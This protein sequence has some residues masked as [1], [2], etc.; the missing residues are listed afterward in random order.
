MLN[1]A[2]YL[3]RS[4]IFAISVAQHWKQ[5]C[6][7]GFGFGGAGRG[8]CHFTPEGLPSSRSGQETGLCNNS[9]VMAQHMSHPQIM[10]K[11]MTRT[12]EMIVIDDFREAYWWLRDKTRPDSRVLSWWDYGYQ[13]LSSLPQ[14]ASLPP[15]PLFPPPPFLL[16]PHVSIVFSFFI[17]NVFVFFVSRLCIL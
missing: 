5:F 2:Q 10:I 14:S 17:F 3:R 12:G 15:H 6:I 11:G 13:V 8:P 1:S 16:L 9:W 7:L 4:M